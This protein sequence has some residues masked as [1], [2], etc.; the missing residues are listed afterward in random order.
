MNLNNFTLKAQESVQKAF[1]IA[2]AKGQQA[3]ECAHI[4]MGVMSEAESMTDFIF[5]KMGVNVG[6]LT[7]EIERLV[8]SYPKVSGADSYVSSTVS[9]AFRKANDNAS[10]M[11]DK[12]VS[13]EHLLMGILD[14]DDRTAHILKDHGVTMK[15]LIAAV[16]ELRKGATVESQTSED[17]FNSLNRFA[18]NLNERARSGKLDPVI[19]RDEEIRRILQI[20]T[21]RTKNNPLLIGEPGVGKTAIAEGLAHRI[22]R[23]D[24]PEDIKSKIIYSLDMGALIAGAKYKG[25]FEERLKSVVNEVV[26]SNGE[27]VLFIDEIHTLVGAGKSEGAMDAANILKPALA[28]GELRAIGATTLSEY[29]K[30]FEKDKALERRFQVVMVDEP[31]RADSIS[32]LR[33]IREKYETHHKVI[34]RDE[35]IIAAVD[36]STRYITDRFLPD[37]AID[38]IDEAA[39][40]LRLEMN[41]VPEEIDEAERTITRLEI[42]KEAV[43]RDGDTV[44]AEKISRELADIQSKRDE[45]K[46]GWKSEKEMI[47][48]VQTKKEAVESLRFEA[49]QAERSGDYGKVAEIRYGKIV[50][51]EKEISDLKELVEKK[52]TKGSLIQEEVRAE[53]I[54]AIVSKWTGIPVSRMLESEKDKLLKL[55]AE[56][57][58]RVV[59]QDEAITAVADAVRRSRAGLQD[60]KK[61]LGSFIF[62][63]T[64]GVGKTELARALAGFLFNDENLLTR[65]DMSEYQERHSVSRLIGA[66]PGYIG[67]DEGGQLTEA[68]RHKPYSVVLLDE[69][70]KAHPD[71]FNLLLQVLDEGR[72]TDNK[73]RTVNF[74]NVIIIMT[75]NLG[76]EMIRDRMDKW[77]NKMPEKEEELLRKE[78]FT[79]LRRTLKPEFLNRVDEIVMFSPLNKDQIREIVK[80]QLGNIEHMLAGYNLKLIVKEDALE[81]LTEKGYD[82]QLGARPV[83]RL[84]QKEIINELSKEIIGGKVLKEDAIVVYAKDGHL[85]FRK[86]TK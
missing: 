18:I 6:S 33:G 51:L 52:R 21:R 85:S 29:Q 61:P 65:I 15:E 63:G 68:V 22:I 13:S 45:L 78:I 72:L 19:G 20:L 36:L 77:D 5:G 32:I 59:G 27:I 2:G 56:L 42:E 39:S 9:E 75:S 86:G 58:K 60:Q 28:R 67:Y 50:E 54:A 57:H 46:A 49:E 23:G 16:S 53:D 8:D 70:E 40:R 82:P 10:R 24:V 69:I 17:T 71:L 79:L 38:L 81:W 83:K 41:S 4:L 43:R 34:I 14:T 25:E 80:I 55:E 35:A 31:D 64:T 1:D 74:R 76:S 7:K 37:K 47:E 12:F 3:V 84:I 66:P 44:K 73:G 62:I 30:Y 26:G 48:K 11:K